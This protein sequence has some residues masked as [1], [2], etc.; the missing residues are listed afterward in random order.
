MTMNISPTLKME[1][2]LLATGWYVGEFL[3]C[4]ATLSEK[5]GKKQR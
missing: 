5:T 2:K 1:G 3:C 4:A